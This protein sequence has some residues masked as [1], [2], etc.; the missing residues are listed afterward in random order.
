[1]SKL[2][3]TI[4]QVQNRVLNVEQLEEF[5][6]QLFVKLQEVEHKYDAAVDRTDQIR[7]RILDVADAIEKGEI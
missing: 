4:G 5:C 1:M 7:K 3:Y 6:I 2:T